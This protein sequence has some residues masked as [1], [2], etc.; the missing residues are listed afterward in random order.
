M[1]SHVWRRGPV[2]A[3]SILGATILVADPE[4]ACAG[5]A[6]ALGWGPAK[7]GPEF[8][9]E[10]AERWGTPALTGASTRFL[11]PPS[12]EGGWI[13]V[14]PATP[15]APAPRPLATTGWRAL[16]LMVRDAE[17][18]V[19]RAR[20]QG[21]RVLGRP[22]RLGTDGSLPLTAGQ[23]VDRD[24]VV[25]YLTQLLSPLPGFRLPSLKGDVD[26]IFMAVLGA[27]DLVKTRDFLEKRIL[28]SRASDRSSPV[29]VVNETLGLPASTSHRLSTLQLGGSHLLEVDQVH[30]VRQPVRSSPSAR[31]V[32]AVTLRA[33]VEQERTLSTPEGALVDLIPQDLEETPVTIE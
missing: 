22:R 21:F 32:V 28:V 15:G 33:D 30:D 18:A 9:V 3:G 2:R 26:G 7:K 24:G 11:H 27:S 14:L 6:A 8:S 29:G 19:E 13:R 1:R 20:D 23:V 5:L 10:E 25:F 16:E 12:G 4:L 17:K 31:G